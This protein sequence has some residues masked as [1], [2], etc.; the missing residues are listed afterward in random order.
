MDI[1]KAIKKFRDDKE[2]SQNKLSKLA[3]LNRGYV[4]KLENNKINPSLSTLEKIAKALDIKVYELIKCA[5]T[6]E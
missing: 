5:E 1:G 3:E 6:E 4:Y 2:I